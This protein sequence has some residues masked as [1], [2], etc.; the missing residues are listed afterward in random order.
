MVT[1]QPSLKCVNRA[2][3]GAVS[4]LEHKESSQSWAA[5]ENAPQYGCS[6]YSSNEK[7]QIR[8]HGKIG[9]RGCDLPVGQD[10]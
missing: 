9:M 6:V 4:P 1:A 2:L 5:E 10:G 8:E 7:R 3:A